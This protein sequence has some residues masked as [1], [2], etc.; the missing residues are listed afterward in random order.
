MTMVPKA[1][2]EIARIEM[3]EHYRNKVQ[4]MLFWAIREKLKN[5]K[6]NCAFKLNMIVLLYPLSI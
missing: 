5:S 6:R 1:S 4:L 2:E 3:N